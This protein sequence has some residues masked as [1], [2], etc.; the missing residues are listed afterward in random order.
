MKKNK[1]LSSILAVA[2]LAV[3][4]VGVKIEADTQVI[5]DTLYTLIAEFPASVITHTPITNV[6]DNSRYFN[7]KIN[8]DF[9][10]YTSAD[11]K[12]LYYI[13]GDSSVVR[14]KSKDNIPNKQDFFIDL[15]Q[16]SETDSSVDY[17]IEV[18]LKIRD[19]QIKMYYPVDAEGNPYYIHAVIASASTVVIN[20]DTGGTIDVGTG[21]QSQGTS[22]IEITPGSYD[23]DHEVTFEE[24]DPSLFGFSAPRLAPSKAS[25]EI[26]GTSPV[27]AYG[28]AID[29]NYDLTLSSPTVLTIAY[30]GMKSGDNFILKRRSAITSSSDNDEDVKI[31]KMDYANKN[32][33]A[34][35]YKTG[36]DL[37]FLA[38]EHSTKDFRPA[39]RVIVKARVES[40]GDAFKFNY[41]TEGDSVKIY[42]VNGKKVREI[43]SG[44]SDGFSWDG[45]DD[46]GRYV[47]SGTYIYQ[48]KV[49]DRSKVISG[50]IAFV[51]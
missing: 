7:A 22:S 19:E 33:I 12:I 49:K 6:S 4:F 38:T 34:K 45:K 27:K 24:L 46:N 36:Y 29:G 20:G 44:T 28:Y 37:L 2:I 13:N 51:K 47:D 42:N 31:E 40:R 35:V 18:T 17:K 16:F 32:V 23:G 26:V 5:S 48:I 21:D 14:E 43:T 9:G 30:D 11:A 8:V 15:P 39:R 10:C 25:L 50:T 41:L 3:L 1:I